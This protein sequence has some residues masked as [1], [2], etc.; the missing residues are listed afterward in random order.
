MLRAL[1]SRFH[2]SRRFARPC[3]SVTPA[4]EEVETR[5][6]LSATLD[7]TGN[8]VLHTEW[9]STEEDFLRLAQAEYAD[10]ISAVA[11]TD[12]PSARAISNAVSDSGGEDKISDRLMSAMIYA[13]GQFIDHDMTLTEGGNTTET[14]SIPI[15]KGDPWFDPAGTGTQVLKTSR[16]GFDE[17]TGTGTSNPRQQVNEIS[18]YLDASMIYGSDA[19]TAAS[20]RTFSGGRMKTSDGNLLPIDS[21]GMFMAGDI[22]ANEN[23]ELTA[24]QTLFVREHNYQA[25]R[26]AKA[27]PTLSDEEVY[28]Q[29]RAIVIAEIQV[30]TYNEWLPSLLGQGS[31]GPYR[32]YNPNVNVGISNEFATAGFRFG[33]SLVGDDIEF[34]DNNGLEVRE[35]VTLADA[36]FN[37]DL[38][39]ENG[40]DPLLKYLTS[41][42]S[43]EV[44]TK[45]VDSVRNFLFGPPGSGGLDLA[46]LNI[47]RGRDHGLADYNQTRAALGLKRVTSFAEITSD[48]ELQTKLKDLY[49][50]VDNI[51]L[52]VGGLAEDHVR[53]GSVGP[54]FKAIILEQFGRLRAGDRYWYQNQF[55]GTQLNELSRTT[56]TDIIRRN[57]QLTSIQ[58]NAFFFKAGVSGTVLVDGN[59]NGKVDRADRPAANAKVQLIL[60]DDGSVVHEEQTDAQG[61]FNFDVSE[62]LRTGIY[63]V[64]VVSADGTVLAKSG[65]VSITGGDDF[66]RV[67]LLIPASS[68]SNSTTPSRPGP[69]APRPLGTAGN[70]STSAAAQSTSG[71][72]TTNGTT[73]NGTSNSTSSTS[74]SGKKAGTT[75][76]TS[77]SAASGTASSTATGADSG[78]ANR[79]A[80]AGTNG[81]MRRL[82]VL[83]PE[84]LDQLFSE[85]T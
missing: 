72:T 46:A 41:D 82:G 24:L 55:K 31:V 80:G 45:I 73:T 21:S 17:A 84:L 59:R 83:P 10:G 7:G 32:G 1:F 54:T 62:D 67:T 8:N 58:K 30:I 35:G 81:L 13:W 57:T 50:T 43:S 11:G 26:I 39:K 70:S 27:N 33:H 5:A 75:G 16:S 42:P 66:E 4:V 51:D 71:S 63:R 74:N 12:R 29:A 20:L 40:I 47:Q 60:V 48:K 52:W 61:N 44:D 65:D 38:V 85:L 2:R 64:Q 77:S 9:G 56:L 36:F 15:P 78:A 49:G 3:A 69:P 79:A 37:P 28:Q 14:M 68:S 76:E 53:A 22:R 25:D 19:E 34:L 23:P 18:A 6:L